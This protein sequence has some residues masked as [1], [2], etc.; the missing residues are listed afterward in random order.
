MDTGTEVGVI[1]T[2][3]LTCQP[4][5]RVRVARLNDIPYCGLQR[6]GVSMSGRKMKERRRMMNPP[7]GHSLGQNGTIPTAIHEILDA[8]DEDEDHI[9]RVPGC[10]QRMQ[11]TGET[12]TWDELEAEGWHPG[13]VRVDGVWMAPSEVPKH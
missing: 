9:C 5:R 13:H 11:P 2:H 7:N 8:H 4:G 10:G 12:G 6:G 3:I 1:W